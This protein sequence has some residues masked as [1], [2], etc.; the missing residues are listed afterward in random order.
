[1]SNCSV[2]FSHT[3]RPSAKISMLK[4]Y[5][6]DFIVILVLPEPLWTFLNIIKRSLGCLT[7][8][9]RLRRSYNGPLIR[10]LVLHCHWLTIISFGRRATYRKFYLVLCQ[11]IATD[12][13]VLPF[14]LYSKL[15]RIHWY[16]YGLL[17]LPRPRTG[18][19]GRR[20]FIGSP[21]NH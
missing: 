8:K 1:M 6:N 19:A 15:T 10:E 3:I 12:A 2:R 5:C 9:L 16:W 17:V 21:S 4:I 7:L 20:H 11:N 14:S 18:P 13:C